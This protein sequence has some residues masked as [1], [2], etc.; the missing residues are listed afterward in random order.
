[1]ADPAS[2][3]ARDA[4]DPDDEEKRTDLDRI[5]IMLAAAAPHPWSFDSKRIIV[6]AADGSGV[7]AWF[8][9]H[10]NAIPNGELVAAAPTLLAECV[11]EIC[12]LRTRLGIE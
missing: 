4:G 1:M 3:A 12:Q 7:T 2:A 10:P 5:D 6:T 9:E 11:A 8:E